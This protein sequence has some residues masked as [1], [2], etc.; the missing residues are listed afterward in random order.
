MSADP[1]DDPDELWVH[2][3]IGAEVVDQAGTRRGVVEQVVDN[4]ASD[5]LELDTGYLVP[6]RFV[7]AL[8]PGVTVTVDVPAGLFDTTDEDRDGGNGGGVEGDG[9]GQ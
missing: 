5:L 7:T 2:E 9:G 4:P 3:L 1:I 6:V 8:D